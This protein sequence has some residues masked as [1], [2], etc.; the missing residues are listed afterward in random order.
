MS[1]DTKNSPAAALRGAAYNGDEPTVRRL[2][3][4][5]VDVNVSDRWGRTALS[6][7]AGK[8]HHEVVQILLGAGAW[9]DPHEDY[10]TYETPLLAAAEN[11]HLDI[12]KALIAAGANPGLHVG[13]SQATP[14]FYARTN[15]HAD[16]SNYLRSLQS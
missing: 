5:G 15:G 1:T 14:E 6:L 12:V 8:G 11:G 3:K 13:V 16:V 9:I 7:A 2:T 4:E 10:D